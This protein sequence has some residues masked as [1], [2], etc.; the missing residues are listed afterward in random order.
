MLTSHWKII[1]D[2]KWVRSDGASVCYDDNYYYTK[3]WSPQHRGW[4]CIPPNAKV[5]INDVYE[6][7]HY[8]TKRG[9]NVSIKFKSAQSAMARI[10]KD[11]PL[12]KFGGSEKSH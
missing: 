8:R 10:D 12:I 9:F 11:F 7:L 6:T 3:E 1:S 2:K 4:Y 5:I